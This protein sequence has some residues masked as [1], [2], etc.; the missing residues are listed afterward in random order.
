MNDARVCAAS[1]APWL[2]GAGSQ[3][4]RCWLLCFPHAGAGSAAYASWSRLLPPEI[5]LRVVQPPGR[6]ARLREPA[7]RDAGSFAR[8]L[9][10]S[11]A[12]LTDRPVALFGHSVGAIVAFEVAREMRRAGLPAP[13]HVYVSGRQAPH[14]GVRGRSTWDLGDKALVAELR[15]LGGTPAALLDDPELLALFLPPLRADL[16]L[17]ECHEFV[18]EEPLDVPITAFAAATDVRAAPD[19]VAEWAAHTTREFALVSV[20]GGH[21]AVMTQPRVVVDRVVGD[22]RARDRPPGDRAPGD[23]APGDRAPGDRAPGDRAPGDRAPGDRAPGD[24]APR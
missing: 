11:V 3:T 19:D 9:V 24:R 4:A 21:F 15:A 7:Y 2:A 14:I 5:G 6:E 23:R 17:N 12:T 10:P 1:G 22:A 8:D 16:E 18:E 20:A 13:C